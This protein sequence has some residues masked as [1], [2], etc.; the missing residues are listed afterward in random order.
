MRPL[1]LALICVVVVVLIFAVYALVAKPTVVLPTQ[2]V[3]LNDSTPLNS[4]LKQSSLN[5]LQLKVR[6]DGTITAAADG[7]EVATIDYTPQTLANTLTLGQSFIPQQ[8]QRQIRAA[9]LLLPGLAYSLLNNGLAAYYLLPVE[10]NV[11]FVPS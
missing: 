11:Q 9:Q 1:Q 4:Y 6:S 3:A 10:L 7:Q 2:T 8:I 5:A